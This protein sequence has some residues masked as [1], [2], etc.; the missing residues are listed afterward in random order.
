MYSQAWAEGGWNQLHS[1]RQHEQVWIAD[2]AVLAFLED[3]LSYGLV[4]AL[5]GMRSAVLGGLLLILLPGF[6]DAE[7]DSPE[8]DGGTCYSTSSSSRTG[9]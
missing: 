5:T 7:G 4:L 9:F 1:F 8:G 6:W 3:I 2:P